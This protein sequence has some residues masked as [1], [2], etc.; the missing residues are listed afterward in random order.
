MGMI[1]KST[2]SETKIFKNFTVIRLFG[3]LAVAVMSLFIGQ[4]FFATWGTV[5]FVIGNTLFFFL[6]NGKD[7]VNSRNK[8]YKG[9]LAWLQSLYSPHK[10]YGENTAEAVKLKERTEEIEKAKLEKHE[11]AKHA[12]S[13]KTKATDTTKE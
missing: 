8:M 1:P 9:Y 4:L 7:I 3:S 2:T 6:L 11:R 13:E 10:F 5:L 12:K